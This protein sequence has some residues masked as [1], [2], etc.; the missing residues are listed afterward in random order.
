VVA[1]VNI[2]GSR[3]LRLMQNSI[4][5]LT[6]TAWGKLSYDMNKIGE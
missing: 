5:D 4:E 6:R 3:Q 2:N 1:V